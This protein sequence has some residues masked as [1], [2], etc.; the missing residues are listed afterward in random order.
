MSWQK[1]GIFHPMNETVP[2]C[3]NTDLMHYMGYREIS[4]LCYLEQQ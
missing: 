1:T 4:Q 3:E 2:M